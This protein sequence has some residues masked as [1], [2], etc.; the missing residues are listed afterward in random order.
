MNMIHEKSSKFLDV[1]TRLDGWNVLVLRGWL[2]KHKKLRIVSGNAASKQSADVGKRKQS[3]PGAWAC[4]YIN[5]LDCN[6]VVTDC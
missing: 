5:L 6:S 1:W 4:N 2:G 3:V